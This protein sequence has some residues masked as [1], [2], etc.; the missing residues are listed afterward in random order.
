MSGV[1]LTIDQKDLLKKYGQQYSSWI[2]GG[3]GK[4][5]VQEH[6]DHEK[7]IQEKLSKENVD[8]L[9]ESQFTEI[10]AKLW[11]SKKWGAKSEWSV[12]NQIISPN[13]GFQ[14]IKDELRNLLY[15]PDDFVQRYN[16]FTKNIRGIRISSISEILNFIFPDKFCLWNKTSKTVLMFFGLDKILSKNIMRLDNWTISGEEYSRC[17]QL[18][19]NIKN[20]LTEFGIEDFIDIDIFFWHIYKDVISTTKKESTEAVLNEGIQSLRK[21]EN[22]S[23]SGRFFDDELIEYL[24]RTYEMRIEKIKRSWFKLNDTVV[25]VNGSKKLSKGEGFYDIDERYYNILIERSNHYYAIVF[26]KPENT[27]VIPGQKLKEIFEG[28]PFYQEAGKPGEWLFTVY[29][30]EQHHMLKLN[31]AKD[32]HDIENFLNQWNQ[33]ANLKSKDTAISD[34]KTDI[35]KK[36]TFTDIQKFILG[37]M[38]MQA[39]YQPI[40]IRTLLESEGLNASKDRIA[41]KIKGLNPQEPEKNFKHIPVYTVLENHRIIRKEDDNNFFLNSEELTA[42]NSVIN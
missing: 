19:E 24:T 20:E 16:H 1:V 40:M 7:Y 41:T 31:N 39:N 2:S 38:H 3:N 36:M 10:Y 14:T 34:M 17:V 21:Q 33:I 37:E 13:G 8:K 6:R 32:E 26:D 12:T 18:V 29:V 9:A 4:E 25:Y 30:K 23:K 5:G 27:F 11:V 22:V 28:H 15:G 42:F 35:I